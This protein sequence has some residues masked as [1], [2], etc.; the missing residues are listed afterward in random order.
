V[1]ASIFSNDFGI[2]FLQRTRNSKDNQLNYEFYQN[3]TIKGLHD[4]IVF[5]KCYNFLRH[6]PPTTA[7]PHQT[8]CFFN[9]NY[10]TLCL[11]KVPTFKLKAYE[12]CYKTI[13]H[14]LHHLRNVAW[15][16]KKSNFSRYSANMDEN[17]N[18]LHFKCTDFNSSMHV[19]VYAECIYVLTE[20]LKY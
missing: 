13:R 11:K 14:D 3:K 5:N 6:R 12:I 9:L 15:K 2:L 4:G 20:Y 1:Q 8:L 7:F 19:T 16:I 17:S 10:T 18:K